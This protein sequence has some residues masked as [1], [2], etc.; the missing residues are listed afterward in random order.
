MRKRISV[1]NLKIFGKLRSASQ[2]VVFMHWLLKIFADLTFIVLR[3]VSVKK[4]AEFGLFDLIYGV[5]LA[6][7]PGG[8]NILEL[9]W[10]QTQ[11]HSV[12]P[13]FP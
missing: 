12:F 4:I 9:D 11:G 2:V 10:E 5:D 1:T 3:N 7:I 8:S 6:H 13:L